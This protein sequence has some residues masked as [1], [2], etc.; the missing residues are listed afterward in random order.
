MYLYFGGAK[1]LDCVYLVFTSLCSQHMIILHC[2][3]L[4][5]QALYRVTMS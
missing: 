4:D 1:T 5:L 3:M 2:D